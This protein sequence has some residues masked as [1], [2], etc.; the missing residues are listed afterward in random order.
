MCKAI[1]QERGVSMA[2]FKAEIPPYREL[3]MTYHLTI[4]G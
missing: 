4:I 1:Q 2:V 3:L